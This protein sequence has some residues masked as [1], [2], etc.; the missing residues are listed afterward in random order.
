[1][2]LGRPPETPIETAAPLALT[3][4]TRPPEEVLAWTE[5]TSP[6]TRAAEAA[7]ARDQRAVELARLASRPDFNL[8]GA[9]VNRGG[10]P[11]LWQASASVMLP[12]RARAVGALAEAQARLAADQAGLESVRLRLR[13]AVAQRLA[14]LSASAE[15]EATYREGLLR[16]GDVAVQSAAAVYS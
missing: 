8:Q 7:V 15:I 5:A 4:D 2:L 1:G 14:F 10:V 13:S 6:E 3:M 16:Q 9:L 12:S 11:P